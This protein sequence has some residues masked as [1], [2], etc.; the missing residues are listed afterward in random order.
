MRTWT[1]K[2]RPKWKKKQQ[3]SLDISQPNA[4]QQNLKKKQREKETT[5]VNLSEQ[6]KSTTR[7][8]RPR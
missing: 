4:E 6:A 8:M 2:I 1:K 3:Q 5:Q 7:V